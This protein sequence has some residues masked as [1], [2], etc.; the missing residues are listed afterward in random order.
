MKIIDGVQNWDP[1]NLPQT[2]LLRVKGQNRGIAQ[3][4]HLGS[5]FGMRIRQRGLRIG[6]SETLQETLL[7]YVG[8]MAFCLW[9]P[10]KIPLNQPSDAGHIG[11]PQ[12]CWVGPRPLTS[13]QVPSAPESCAQCWNDGTSTST[14]IPCSSTKLKLPSLFLSLSLSVSSWCI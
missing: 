10:A 2:G 6:S 12:L 11:H 7:G 4:C 1:E 14:S 13:H 3:V 8:L 5:I 9:F